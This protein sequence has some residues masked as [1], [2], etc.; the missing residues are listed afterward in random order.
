MHIIFLPLFL[1]LTR[2]PEYID[3]ASDGIMKNNK[4]QC[5]SSIYDSVMNELWKSF[6]RKEVF[7]EI[8]TVFFLFLLCSALSLRLFLSLALFA[9]N[10]RLCLSN[11][12][13]FSLYFHF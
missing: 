5:G 11:Y 3:E 6:C 9:F 2:A 13:L 4:F 7:K 12:L 10:V 8:G 1:C